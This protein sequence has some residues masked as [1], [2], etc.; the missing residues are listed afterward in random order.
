MK[1]TIEGLLGNPREGS[2][3]HES[4]AV[5]LASIE[6]RREDGFE[7]TLDVIRRDR[8]DALYACGRLA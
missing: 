2:W 8:P 7:A 4:T 5:A 3:H 6:F 1:I